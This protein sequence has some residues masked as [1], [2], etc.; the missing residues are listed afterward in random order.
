MATASINPMILWTDLEGREL[1]GRWLVGRLVRPEGRTAWFTATGLDGRPAMLS[2]TE[3]L[4]DESE[5]LTR[6]RAASQIRDTHVVTVEDAFAAFI[7]ETPV[8]VAAMEPT[9]ED[10]GDVLRERSLSPPEAQQVLEALVGGMAAIHARGMAHGRMDPGSVLAMGETIKLRSDCLQPEANAQAMAED[11]R[12]MAKIVVQA[13]TRRI[14]SGENDP[15]L[16]LLPEPTARSVR[17]A[18]SGNAR[19]GEIAALAGVQLAASSMPGAERSAVS[20]AKAEAVRPGPVMV[21]PAPRAEVAVPKETVKADAGASTNASASAQASVPPVIPAET[22][23]AAAGASRPTDADTLRPGETKPS[24]APRAIADSP[25]LLE[26]DEPLWNKRRSA[27]WILGAA[28]LVLIATIWAVVGL[29]HRGSA[30]SSGAGVAATAP[31]APN[32]QAAPASAQAASVAT[33]APANSVAV[34]TTPGWRVVAYTYRHEAQAQHKAQTLTQRYPT[35]HP[36]VFALHG[37]APWLV[38]LGGVMSKEQAFALRNQ[39][40]RM[41]L[42]KDTYAQNYR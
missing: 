15:V 40:V 14:P 41:G 34:A 3:A 24:A 10:L 20:D 9:E 7:D 5:L 22:I 25:L 16:Q 21:V 39:A 1:F 19:I 36:G 31:A 12:G 27:P 29:V 8:V 17:R 2:I 13:V 30:K 33:P 4:N 18:L 23:A 38:T 35:L 11:V 26:D 28:V 37:S 32:T 6:L 42:P